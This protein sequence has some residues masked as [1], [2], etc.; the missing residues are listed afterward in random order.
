[1][2]STRLREAEI[3]VSLADMVLRSLMSCL[4]EWSVGGAGVTGRARKPKSS[5]FEIG[6]G[7]D[8]GVDCPEVGIE[9]AV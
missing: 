2:L 9:S 4:K 7:E 5:S 6:S 3:L 1:M 8:S